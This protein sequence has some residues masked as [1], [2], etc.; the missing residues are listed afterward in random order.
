MAITTFPNG[1]IR[2]PNMPDYAGTLKKF[3]ESGYPEDEEEKPESSGV[4]NIKLTDDEAKDLQ[5]YQ[6]VG[7]EIVIEATGELEGTTFRIT[8]GV[9][10]ASGAGGEQDVNADAEEVMSKFR[11]S[12]MTQSKTIPSP[13]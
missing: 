4:R 3:R 6:K 8:G 11:P 13:S 7:K 2:T 12:P 9:K 5:P 1:S 10:Y